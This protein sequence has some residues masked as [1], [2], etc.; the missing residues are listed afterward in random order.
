MHEGQL[1]YERGIVWAVARRMDRAQKNSEKRSKA[2]LI[3][4]PNHPC[5]S[6]TRKMGPIDWE[7]PLCKNRNETT[8]RAADFF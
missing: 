2:D 6:I 4:P 8:Q 3:Y 7:G 5:A 1:L